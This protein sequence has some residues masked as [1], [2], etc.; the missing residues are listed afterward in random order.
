M[1]KTWI[2]A[3][4]MSISMIVSCKHDR[5][6][7]QKKDKPIFVDVLVAGLK[8]V[9]NTIEVNGN[10]Q[11]EDMVEIRP[12]VN[13]KLTFLNMADGERVKKGRVIARV[14][15]A[16][17]QAQLRQQKVHLELA[18]KTEQRLKT[19]LD[20]GGAN[21][22]EYDAAKGQVNILLSSVQM[23]EAQLSKTVIT[24]PFDGV[25]GLRMVSEGAYVTPST[26]ITTLQQTERLKIDFAVPDMYINY[27]NVGDRVTIFPDDSSKKFVATIS[28]M[29]PQVNSSTRSVMV[30]AKLTHGNLLPGSFVKVRI[31]QESNSVL[32]PTN[33]IIPDATSNQVVVLKEGRAIFRDVETGVRTSAMVELVK[34]VN[35]G[36]SIVV[37]GVL[38]VRPNAKVT[39]KSV[40]N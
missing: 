8:N 36:D 21:Q 28:A 12:E 25:L 18:E 22:Q 23:V 24:A 19:L 2:I 34:G 5:K 40:I 4:V 16:D 30:R 20:A 1:D 35:I 27:I 10:V 7:T 38:F 37:G 11:S 32:V 39:V 31:Q 13:G 9:G 6:D 17:L 26:V 33:A 15:D 29:E 14:N 3:G